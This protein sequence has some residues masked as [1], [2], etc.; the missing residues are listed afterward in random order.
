MPLTQ[1]GAV[2]GDVIMIGEYDFD[3]SP[4]KTNPYIPPELLAQDEII[5]ARERK[6]EELRWGRG[7]VVDDDDEVDGVGENDMS[8]MM[9]DL[10]E[11]G[12]DDDYDEDDEELEIFSAT[13]F[14]E[15]DD[16][17]EFVYEEGDEVF[18]G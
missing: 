2:E 3:F 14:S 13:D 8:V 15:L 11:E 9:Y 7:D 16:G 17:V 4:A 18:T 6:R 12:G 1:I 5:L 10:S